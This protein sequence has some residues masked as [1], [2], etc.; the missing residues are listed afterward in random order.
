VN[1]P[2]SGS[3]R[4]SLPM[5]AL[6]ASAGGLAVVA[7]PILFFFPH[8]TETYFAWAIGHPL[9]PVF[10]GASYLA[11]IGTFWAIRLNRWSV[12]RVTLPSIIVF[13]TG[14]LLATLLHLDIFNWSHPV[15]W[16]WLAIYV[17]SPPAALILFLVAE[18]GRREDEVGDLPASMR[19]VMAAFTVLFGLVGLALLL[20]PE[21]MAEF[22]PWS[23]TGLTARVLGGWYLAS[24][25]LAAMLARERRLENAGIGLGSAVIV[26]VLLVF[27]ALLHRNDFNGPPASVTAY[28]FTV[29]LYGLA[30]AAFLRT[31]RRSAPVAAR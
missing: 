23:L 31:A 27:G 12:A 7:G 5:K 8:D 28:L 29:V 24:A 19:P 14:Q 1:D 16:A 22:W 30:S 18:R 6:L 15:A 20:A 10:M 17:L 11:G 2:G 21:T 9:T 26:T 4:L 13:G 25:A 3:E